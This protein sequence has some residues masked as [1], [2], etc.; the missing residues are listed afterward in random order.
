MR[1]H[2]RV[3][4]AGL[5]PVAVRPAAHGP[6]RQHLPE[7]GRVDVAATFSDGDALSVRTP[8][9]API[10][11][12]AAVP[13][14]ALHGLVTGEAAARLAQYGPNAT[15]DEATSMWRRVL[16]KFSSPVPWMLE[17]ATIF[18]LVLGDY[19][20]AGVIA[21]LLVFNA[22]LGLVQEGRAQATLDALKSRL[23]PN[24]TVLRDGRWRVVPA[25][26]LVPGDVIK[27][28]LGTIVGAD[29]TILDGEVSLDHS[30]LTGESLSVDGAAGTATYAGAL[31]RRGEAA[32]K[33]TATGA[34]TA[35][36][37]TAELVR[38]AHAASSQERAVLRVVRNLALFDAVVIVLQT[39]VAL[40]FRLPPVEIIPLVLTAILAAIPV[41]LPATF[42]LASTLGARMLASKGVLPTRLS[43]IDEAATMDVLCSDKTGTLTQ[44]ALAVADTWAEPATGI[45]TMLGLA[46]LAS[47]DGGSDAVDAAV[48][49][50]AAQSPTD[51]LPRLC[52]FIPFNPGSKTSEAW[53]VDAAGHPLHIVKGA[54]ARVAAMATVAPD[55]A[56]AARQMEERGYRVLGVAIGTADTL[57]GI[58]LIALS[59]PPRAD[60]RGLIAELTGMGVRVVMVTGDA[61]VTARV[62]AD[63]VGLDGKT[64]SSG[65]RLDALHPED[66]G[67]YAGVLPEDKYRIVRAFQQGGHT[68][69]MCGDGANDAPALRQAQMGVAVST[70][71][72][73][74]KSAAGIVLTEP[75][76]G[77]IVVATREGRI[78]FQR[79][80][81]YVLRSLTI[82]VE[83]M[84]FLTAGLVMLGH[85]ILTP[86]LTVIL[87][88]VSDF[89]VMSSTTDN[90]RPSTQ[91]NAWRIDRLTFAGTLMGF[92]TLTFA[93]GVIAIGKYGLR[94]DLDHIR[95]LAAVVTVFVGQ[96]VFYVVRERK[97]VWSSR[98]SN[99]VLVS[100]ACDIGIITLLATNGFLM[101]ALPFA[102]VAEV[103][104]AAA[105]FTLVLDALRAALFR[106]WQMV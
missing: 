10:T 47:S 33:V 22:A 20:Q 62:V 104:L 61:P 55:G 103:L 50:A 17:A 59:D 2:E 8:S 58:G 39:V 53:V 71:T 1:A 6:Q 97:H 67:V 83:Q 78:V 54:Y 37:R 94:L 68:V 77:G 81:T 12:H 51:D 3:R 27:L 31:V 88:T 21:F 46:A 91:P 14:P 95:T 90:V 42:T 48:R 74:A 52:K 9:T 36:G 96:A 75:G 57:H 86:M 106:R 64:C 70:A 105:C 63:A 32:A 76:L 19:L 44:N 45:A 85:A 98:P 25:R 65:V 35:F 34:R 84:L 66:F 38:I 11:V 13:P 41:A 69:G 79:I 93:I 23:A 72:D 18:E 49:A 7:A 40:W 5:H 56:V 60:A 82:K 15:P 29:A 24:A 16:A 101:A 99:W 80:L 28:S 26:E 73:V 30:T 102:M 89:L 92:A 4:L 43:A 87:M 100:S